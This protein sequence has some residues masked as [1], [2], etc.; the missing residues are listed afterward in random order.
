ME[1][2]GNLI[3]QAVPGDCRQFSFSGEKDGLVTK[4]HEVK[5]KH[6]LYCFDCVADGVV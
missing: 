4:R 1:P 2:N 3:M 6:T 5:E